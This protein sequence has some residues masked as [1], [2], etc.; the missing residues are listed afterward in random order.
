MHSHR[1][2]YPS[3]VLIMHVLAT[4]RGDDYLVV[5]AIELRTS[6]S[7]CD[8]EFLMGAGYVAVGKTRGGKELPKTRVLTAA[9]REALDTGGGE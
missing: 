3:E 9:G 6:P 7:P 4:H 1:D 2:L 5:R 8:E